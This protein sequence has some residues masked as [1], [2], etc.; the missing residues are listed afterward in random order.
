MKRREIAVVAGGNSSEYE[1]SLRSGVG[2]VEWIDR[3][4]YRP[5]LV[6]MRAEFW[7]VLLPDGSRR[8]VDKGSFS[9]EADEGLIRFDLAYITIHGTPG[10][11]GLLQGYFELMGIPYTGCGVLA[12][13]LSFNKFTCNTYLRAFGVQVAESLA[14]RRGQTIGPDEVAARVG[15]PCFVKPNVGGSSFGVSK[16]SHAEDLQQA[17][18]RAFAEGEEVI[19]EAFVSGRELTCGIFHAKGRNTL[20]P[21]TEV[22]SHNE[23]FDYRAKYHGEVEEI[24]PAP[25]D[26]SLKLR[27]HSLTEA[28]YSIL[29][30]RGIVR[31]DYIL[32]PSGSITLLEVNTTPGMTPTSF[33]PQQ[34]AAAGLNM[35][36]VLTELIEEVNN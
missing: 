30:C 4:R 21:I 16:V 32:A 26:E 7:E 15:F 13:A 5:W 12:S 36:E 1:V 28:I 11:N 10:E 19:I 33:I 3:E 24:T 27:I 18:E 8:A 22:R 31:A 25:I 14:L 29:G 35:T 9:F 6:L 23:F 17:I 34:V 20:L 2:I